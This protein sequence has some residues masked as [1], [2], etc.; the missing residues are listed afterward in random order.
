MKKWDLLLKTVKWN[1]SYK[2]EP[3]YLVYWKLAILLADSVFFLWSNRSK[4]SPMTHGD[5][6]KQI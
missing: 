2:C 5:W 4:N 1:Y 3:F 6:M